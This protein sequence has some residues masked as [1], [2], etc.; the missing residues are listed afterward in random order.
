[1]NSLRN[2]IRD[3]H[4]KLS[5]L[6]A[7]R[8]KLELK[9]NLEVKQEVAALKQHM[10]EML[11]QEVGTIQVQMRELPGLSRELSSLRQAAEEVRGLPRLLQEVGA[12]RQQTAD[13]PRLLQE[14][15]ALRQQTAEMKQAVGELSAVKELASGLPQVHQRLDSLARQADE[16]P[17]VVQELRLLQEACK[18]IPFS[19]KQDLEDFKQLRSQ[20]SKVGSDLKELQSG[21][22]VEKTVQKEVSKLVKEL[23]RSGGADLG[24][25]KLAV[26]ENAKAFLEFRQQIFDSGVLAPKREVPPDE[27]QVPV[28]TLELGQDI[29]A[30]RLLVKLG[31]AKGRQV[32]AKAALE[33]EA[34]QSES[35]DD[36]EELQVPVE[37]NLDDW[38]SGLKVPE[39]E[40]G[41]HGY[42]SVTTGWIIVCCFV[43]LLQ[44]IIVLVLMRNMWS[45]SEFGCVEEE[46]QGSKWCV[47]HLSKAAAAIVAGVL[48][49]KELMDTVNFW[50]VSQLL[51]PSLEATLSACVRVFTIVL[52]LAT[53]A[54]AF[55][56]TYEPVDLFMNMTALTFVGDIGSF[57]LDIAKRGVLGHHI[58]KTMTELNFQLNLNRE[59]PSWFTTVRA[60]TL[61]LLTT[62]TVGFAVF[63][64][65]LPDPVCQTGYVGRFDDALD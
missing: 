49:G 16:V 35:S 28:G 51:Q 9:V 2:W 20:V 12:L 52:I 40:K 36:I 43:M 21:S 56:T 10:E 53:N 29:F 32:K 13:L 46:L 14:M 60:V 38:V 62:C 64:F 24:T 31:L 6:E 17:Q 33:D 11:Q 39:V 19:L 63:L 44:V 50:M 23:D 34:S 26:A 7:S 41:K 25:L 8:A 55:R 57:G 59:Y 30:A 22:S 3:L 18:G 54:L 27:E 45:Q 1:M 4:Q 37:V 48:A 58:S 5:S 15:G 47:L 65:G 42:Y 61:L